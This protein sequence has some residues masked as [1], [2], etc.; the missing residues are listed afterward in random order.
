MN[1]FLCERISC[2]G[3]GACAAVCAAGAIALRPDEEGFLYPE[4]DGSRCLNC[5]ACG[6]VCPVAGEKES[7]PVL[8]ALAARCRDEALRRSSSSGGIF[9]LLAQRVLARGGAVYGAAFAPDLRSVRHI[10]VDEPA[11][12]ALLRGSKY[13]Q[14]APEDSFSDAAQQLKQGRWVLY[15][16]TPCQTA[17]LKR[18][19]GDDPERLLTVDVI[20][21]GAASPAPWQTYLDE[22]ERSAGARPCA[23]NLRDKSRGWGKFRAALFFED[24]TRTYGTQIGDPFLRAYLQNAALRESCYGCPFKGEHFAGDI[25]LG[26]LWGIRHLSLPPELNDD[27][28]TSLVLLRSQKGRT[29]WESAAREALSAEIDA[30]QALACNSAALRPVKRPAARDRFFSLLRQEGLQAAAKQLCPLSF[31]ERIKRLLGR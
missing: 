25:T 20:C 22:A 19:L 27:G 26:D 15:S 6:A 3:C 21:H 18:F 8:R 11:Q 5:G 13:I 30:A 17:A 28:G 7:R 1:T 14:S 4:T 9:S 12:L 16:G 23:A 2:T 24:G 31:K 10:R 29:L